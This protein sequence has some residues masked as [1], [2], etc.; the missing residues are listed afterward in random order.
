MNGQQ[1]HLQSHPQAL[2]AAEADDVDSG[3]QTPG[4]ACVT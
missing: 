2:L 1:S 4:Q 3:P